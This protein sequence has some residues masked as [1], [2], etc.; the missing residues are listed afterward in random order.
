MMRYI[1]NTIHSPLHCFM[2]AAGFITSHDKACLYVLMGEMYQ[3]Y[4]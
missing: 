3:L 1:F 2:Q 4:I